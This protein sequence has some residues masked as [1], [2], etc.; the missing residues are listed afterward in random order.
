MHAI[1]PD[2]TLDFALGEV[3]E[4][5]DEFLSQGFPSSVIYDAREDSFPIV[6][7]GEWLGRSFAAV[8]YLPEHPESV[9]P[10]QEIEGVVEELLDAPDSLYGEPAGYV[11]GKLPS[12][13]LPSLTQGQAKRLFLSHSTPREGSG[14]YLE[15]A[16]G[17]GIGELFGDSSPQIRDALE[18][19]FSYVT[20]SPKEPADWQVVVKHYPGAGNIKFGVFASARAGVLRH[21]AAKYFLA[22]LLDNGLLGRSQLNYCQPSYGHDFEVDGYEAAQDSGFSNPRVGIAGIYVYPGKYDELFLFGK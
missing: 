18:G 17:E 21:D 12:L 2:K 8:T 19:F 13:K 7:S 14:A 22:S 4:S 6:F 10:A 11:V 16:L 20:G 15:K 3:S 5:F 9:F 1:S